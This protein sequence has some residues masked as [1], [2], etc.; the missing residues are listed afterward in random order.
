MR[1]PHECTSH[2]IV[3]VMRRVGVSHLVD[4]GQPGAMRC[5]GD[6]IR[7]L[8]TRVRLM[9]I[10]ATA[11]ATKRQP[12]AAAAT[13]AATTATA[14]AIK[15]AV[16]ATADTSA[17]GTNVAA[18]AATAIASR[19]CQYRRS[20][21]RCHRHRRDRSRR[22]RRHRLVELS[23][24]SVWHL[25]LLLSRNLPLAPRTPLPRP[26]EPHS[27]VHAV[28]GD[29]RRKRYSS[30]FLVATSFWPASDSSKRGKMSS[31][32]VLSAISCVL[33]PTCLIP[34]VEN[35]VLRSLSGPSLSSFLR[36]S[37]SFW[38]LSAPMHTC[39]GAP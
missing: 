18:S 17:A 6:V 23:M 27:E 4:V 31:F 36:A 25:L 28:G 32:S 7:T 33:N 29:E 8:R 9:A 1:M 26:G 30:K 37:C 19:S 2:V 20:H 34:V 35:I 10:A 16:A 14:A 22:H 5:A 38:T 12:S 3:R 21:C 24:P 39:F 13:L 15:A 11:A